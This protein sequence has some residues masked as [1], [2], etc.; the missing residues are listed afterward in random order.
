[1]KISL[2]QGILF[3]VF[4]L[5]ALI[6]IFVFATYSSNGNGGSAVGTVVIWGTL[7]K[8]GMQAALTAA[9]QAD[10]LLKNVSYVQKDSATL[11]NDIAS[12]IATGGAPD[13]VLASQEE[14]HSLAKFI[15]PIPASTLSTSAFTNTFVGEGDLFASP[16][17]YYGVPFLIDPLVLF[18]NRAILA[19]SGIAKPPS[20][21]EALMGL[22]PNVAILSPTRQITRGLVALGTYD[23]VHNAR[24]I[25]ST[26][27]IQ[28]NVSISSYSSGGT[29]SSN[30]D[31]N[32]SGGVPPGE[33]VLGFYTQFAD[34]SKVSYT[35]NASLPDSQQAFKN[36]DLALYFGYASE[37][38]YLTA[39][40]PNLNF[41][42]APLPQPATASVKSAYGLVYALMI[43]RGAKNSSGAYQAAVLLTNAAEQNAAASA[44][45][46]APA[47]LNELATTPADPAA[48][49]AYAEA[50]YSKGWL[51]PTPTDT[52]SVFSGMITD[53]ISGRS[54]PS[55]ALNSAESSL[56]ALL[57][58]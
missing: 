6:G 56:T 44:T 15:T 8:K 19:S 45:G 23:N 31:E 10:S 17:G 54:T 42:V 1:M 40:N 39:A 28:A 22:V 37:A 13:L 35:W 48:A 25:L 49:V 38:R 24:G 47:V 2:F 20:T 52:D 43:P 12:A 14:L 50:L 11:T 51:S 5:G 3:G 26:L 30:L 7:P 55:V 53:V 27:F 21:W 4:G 46:L 16:S 33:S 32:A 34:P 57:R 29:L 41:G 58:K 9:A 36:G 18:S